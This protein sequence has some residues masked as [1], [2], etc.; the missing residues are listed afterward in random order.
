MFEILDAQNGGCFWRLKGRNGEILCH[1]E[2]YV[3]KSNAIRG[4][5]DMKKYVAAAT[6]AD[7]TTPAHPWVR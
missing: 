2:V 7:R 3:S 1:S 4:V 6:M 5:E